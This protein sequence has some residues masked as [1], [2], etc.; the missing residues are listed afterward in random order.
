MDF[1]WKGQIIVENV[2]K[3]TF[4]LAMN[5][6]SEAS[7]TNSESISLKE[8]VKQSSTIHLLH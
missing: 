5:R 3:R 6:I 2:E 7:Y 1:F 8:Y 4:K